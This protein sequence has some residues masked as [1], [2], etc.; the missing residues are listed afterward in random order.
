MAEETS[1]KVGEIV[2][3]DLR[4]ATFLHL[5]SARLTAIVPVEAGKCAFTFKLKNDEIDK[6]MTQWANGNPT[7][8]VRDIINAYLY[9]V[10]R[11]KEV[12]R[13]K[14]GWR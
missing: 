1:V 4:L 5:N 12:L 10:H 13:A 14:G 8:G 11:G 3:K 2:T 7:A 9:L 6:L